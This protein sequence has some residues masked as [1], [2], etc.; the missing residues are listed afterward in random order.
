VP[1][2]AKV[3]EEGLDGC[4]G[5]GLDIMTAICAERRGAVLLNREGERKIPTEELKS[6]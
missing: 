4:L 6:S 2:S 1:A 5:A 3:A